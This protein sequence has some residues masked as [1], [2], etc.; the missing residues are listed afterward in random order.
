LIAAA[1]AGRQARLIEFDPAYC[2]Q[3]LHR[4]ERATGKPARLANRPELRGRG[5]SPRVESHLR[6]DCAMSDR[7]KNS[8]GDDFEV[9]YGKPPV[10]TRFRKGQ[11]GNP[12]WR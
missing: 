1:K 9:G 6:R 3:I 2:D 7:L 12:G 4:F 8:E 10:R 11:T 5:R